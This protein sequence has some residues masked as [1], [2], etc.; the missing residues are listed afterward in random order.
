MVSL[1]DENVKPGRKAD[2]VLDGA[3]DVFMAQGFEGASVDDIARAARV[4]KAT[5]YSYYPDKRVLF[6]HVLK[7]ECTKQANVLTELLEAGGTT[8]E[9]LCNIAR[10]FVSFLVTPVALSMFRIC[11]AESDRFPEVSR[12]FYSSGPEI[13]RKRMVA[14]LQN[15]T[16][17]GDLE[18][19][20]FGLAADQLAELCRADLFLLCLLGLKKDPDPD[21]IRYVA[22]QAVETFLARFA[23]R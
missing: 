6:S 23:R 12:A 15:A 22:D 16:S 1:A 4:S 7:S 17:R 20:D 21:E 3:R 2:Q 8:R 19:E 5:L 11:V 10:S 9:V 18:I 14:F 13:M